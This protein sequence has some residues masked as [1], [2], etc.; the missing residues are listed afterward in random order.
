MA[1]RRPDVS[2]P[3]TL[4]KITTPTDAAIRKIAMEVG[5]QVVHHIETMHPEMAAAAHSWKSARLSI[6]NFTHNAIIA[7]VNAADQGLDQQAIAAGEKHR[8]V[9][10]R[11]RKAKTVEDI[12]A[13]SKETRRDHTWRQDKDQ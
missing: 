3:E 7:A 6:R 12:V 5:K 2:T 1:M 10:N 4:P 13:A 8:R 11:L 9:I